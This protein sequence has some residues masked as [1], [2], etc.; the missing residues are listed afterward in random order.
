MTSLPI[1][2]GLL[3]LLLL[4]DFYLILKRIK[5]PTHGN[6]QKFLVVITKWDS[7]SHMQII[8]FFTNTLRQRMIR[9]LDLYNFGDESIVLNPMYKAIFQSLPVILLLN[10]HSL[11]SSK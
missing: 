1:N 10:S 2:V 7:F 6:K 4:V 9:I 11:E 3:F 5:I 8:V